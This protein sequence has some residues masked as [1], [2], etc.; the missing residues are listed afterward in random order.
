MSSGVMN[1][2][3][4]PLEL[5]YVVNEELKHRLTEYGHEKR[6]VHTNAQVATT[7]KI[8]LDDMKCRSPSNHL[9]HCH[10]EGGLQASNG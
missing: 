9:L 3:S 6:K 4:N 2:C 1:V 7:V 10:L 8:A 5:V